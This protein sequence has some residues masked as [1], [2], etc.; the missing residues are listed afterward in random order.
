[1]TSIFGDDPIAPF[2]VLL[3]IIS[4]ILALGPI[5]NIARSSQIFV[6]VVLVMMGVVFLFACANV[7]KENL[8]PVTYLDA[9][10]VLYGMEPIIMLMSCYF[11]YTFLIGHMEKREDDAKTV[12]RWVLLLTIVVFLILLST[13]GNLSAELIIDIKNPFFTMVQDISAFGIIERMEAVAVTLWCI[14]DVVYIASLLLAIK[15][16]WAG[17]L[18]RKPN[19]WY[20]WIPAAAA[21]VTALFILPE[22]FRL[23]VLSDDFIPWATI[24]MTVG[25]SFV[26]FLIGKLRRKI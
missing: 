10:E 1:M 18:N 8:L 25:V 19:K 7:R 3:L 17:A 14:S 20:V 6:I 23:Q 12:R 21:L 24:V 2:V 5:R 4:V 9:P 15:E 13:I 16:L 26:I 22:P 11:Y